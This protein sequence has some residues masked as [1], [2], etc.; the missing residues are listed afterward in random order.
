MTGG[1]KTTISK[2]ISAQVVD[3]GHG[4]EITLE[5]SDGNTETLAFP[6][7][8]LP[9]LMQGLSAAGNLASQSRRAG[10][11]GM[12]EAVTPMIMKI[13]GRTGQTPDGMI[14]FEFGLTEGFPVRLAMSRDQTVRTIE[15][16]QAEL[17]KPPPKRSSN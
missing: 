2:I 9:V 14:L 15:L 4:I 3:Y 12:V 7:E 13:H 5:K 10:P 11:G 6:A 16:L 17:N 1:P 8:L